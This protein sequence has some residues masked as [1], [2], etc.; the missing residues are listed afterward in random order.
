MP[1]QIDIS[2]A[3]KSYLQSRLGKTFDQSTN[4]SV[5]DEEIK[6]NYLFWQ[7][8][9]SEIKTS[10][11]IT[12]LDNSDDSKKLKDKI[13]ATFQAYKKYFEAQ[14]AGN[15]EIA[16]ILTSFTD[17]GNFFNSISP[18]ESE[19]KNIAELI[20]GLNSYLLNLILPLTEA[21]LEESKKEEIKRSILSS[22]INFPG[23]NNDVQFAC[24]AGTR[25]R[26]SLASLSSSNLLL[27]QRVVAEEASAKSNEL[28]KTVY[29]G[30]RA[31]CPSFLLYSLSF[32]TDVQ[33]TKLDQHYKVPQSDISLFDVIKIL[34]DFKSNSYLDLNQRIQQVIEDYDGILKRLPSSENYQRQSK[35]LSDFQQKVQMEID[36]N[37]LKL[38]TDFFAIIQ[39]DPELH[40]TE[41]SK[42]D[43]EKLKTSAQL[44]SEFEQHLCTKYP[45]PYPSLLQDQQPTTDYFQ[46]LESLDLFYDQGCTN[47]LDPQKMFN[48][49]RLFER[50]YPSDLPQDQQRKKNQITV[51]IL[52]LKNL[53]QNFKDSNHIYLLAFFDE[54]QRKK[55]KSFDDFLQELLSSDHALSDLLSPTIE[56]IKQKREELGQLYIESR[57][58]S[59]ILKYVLF[60]RH[61]QFELGQYQQYNEPYFKF[62][63]LIFSPIQSKFG[64]QKRN[65]LHFLVMNGKTEII[66]RIPPETLYTLLLTEAGDRSKV[67]DYIIKSNNLEI[68]KI[69]FDKLNYVPHEQDESLFLQIAKEYNLLKHSSLYGHHQITQFLIEKFLDNRGGDYLSQPFS[70]GQSP[71][72]TAIQRGYNEVAKILIKH[73]LG[74]EDLDERQNN[75]LHLAISYGNT[76]IAKLLIEKEVGIRS[77]NHRSNTPLYL[78]CYK[79]HA[80]VVRLLLIKNVEVNARDN[81][82]N[83]SL[84][85]ASY[86]GHTEIVELLLANKAEVNARDNGDNT[87]LHFAVDKGHTEIVELLLANKAEVNARDNNGNTS[88]HVASYY[89]HAEIVELLLAKNAEVNASHNRGNTSLHY[90]SY[91]GHTEV[92]RL[93]LANKAEVNAKNNRGSTSLHDA[94]YYGHAKIVELLLA[95]NAE[96]NARD[97]VYNTPLHCACQKGHTEVVKILLEKGANISQQN[98]QGETALD[99]ATQNET[100]DTINL[101]IKSSEFL[102]CINENNF[103]SAGQLLLEGA[104]FNKSILATE[105]QDLKTNFTKF[106][107]DAVRNN[108]TNLVGILIEKLGADFFS[109]RDAEEATLLHM[110]CENNSTNVVEL[111]T[112]EHNSKPSNYINFDDKNKSTP[113]H[114]ASNRGHAEVVRLLLEKGAQI[115]SKEYSGNDALCY[116]SYKGHIDVVRLLL[117]KGAKISQ[118]DNQ[119]ETALHFAVDKGHT[120]VVRLLIE[121]GAN[122]SQQNDQGETALDIAIRNEKTKIVELLTQHSQSSQ[123]FEDLIRRDN[124]ELAEKLLNRADFDKSILATQDQDLKTKFT[125]FVFDAVVNN[126]VDVIKILIE[127]LGV[128]FF[129]ITN[130]KTT[131]IQYAINSYESEKKDLTKILLQEFKKLKQSEIIDTEDC[132]TPFHY[133][134]HFYEIESITSLVKI[135]VESGYD[136]NA[137]SKTKKT[138]LHYVVALNR[139][140]AIEILLENEASINETSI[141]GDTALH[142]AVRKDDLEAIKILLEN[143]ADHNIEN[144]AGK[145]PIECIEAKHPQ[146]ILDIEVIFNKYIPNTNVAGADQSRADLPIGRG[147]GGG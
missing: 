115:D 74:Q 54:F 104:I 63:Q 2:E 110:A 147:G 72:I 30:N 78:A 23:K 7:K 101:L 34:K 12:N 146:T 93:L 102:R 76:E 105:D 25:E 27:H 89:G 49:L 31:H 39:D 22:L 57:D 6:N 83:T 107:F 26:I 119:G 79:G 134:S 28:S 131:I 116:A 109:L 145:K 111:L 68:L 55:E 96:V 66:K 129:D 42:I 135:L 11:S 10:L 120:E 81:D 85:A 37:L 139:S 75:A 140:E 136:I 67:L 97:N 33:A 5:F 14:F 91:K 52:I 143:G 44:Q 80:E 15:L 128:D 87:P 123:S 125:K 9:D 69:V 122:I 126:E 60:C 138:A 117:E 50:I 92:V 137:K 70:H 124:F 142:I 59:E 144:I 24:I 21:V 112:K 51:A 13:L 56:S 98:D 103:E 94:S 82:G 121:S 48:L 73:Q 106:V 18:S 46:G 114:Y 71:L 8:T 20:R 130:G 88:L 113:L 53:C 43:R 77:I 64:R 19:Y 141:S 45:N 90:A 40:L 58:E 84:H 86:K 35:L 47:L 65:I 127:K 36:S 17:Q 32:L 95:N 99:I 132:Y 1:I 62:H 61:E 118:Q 16:P 133:L 41:E 108:K 38:I 4:L 3:I 100:T 29:L